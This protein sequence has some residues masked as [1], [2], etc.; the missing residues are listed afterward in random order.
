MFQNFINPTTCCFIT[1]K[2]TL[3]HTQ[4]F[5]AK[6]AS[7]YWGLLPPLTE[8]QYPW[9]ELQWWEELLKGTLRLCLC[10]CGFVHTHTH[11][12]YLISTHRILIFTGKTISA[13]NSI[14]LAKAR[15]IFAERRPLII[16]LAGWLPS[17]PCLPLF[18]TLIS[19]NSEKTESRS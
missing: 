11:F 3:A 12:V 8:F 15:C 13:R 9:K 4:C 2:Y 17:E 18:I 16:T 19:D 7:I 10:V 14:I 1:H 6:Q 5:L